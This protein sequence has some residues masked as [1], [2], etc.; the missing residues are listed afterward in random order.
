MLFATEDSIK[1]CGV[2]KGTG[3]QKETITDHTY[4]I[5]TET[6]QYLIQEDI[7]KKDFKVILN[8]I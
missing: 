2:E 5:L 4:K 6:T 8:K 1:A 3:K 7:P